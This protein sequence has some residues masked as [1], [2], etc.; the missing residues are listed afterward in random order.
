MLDHESQTANAWIENDMSRW[1]KRKAD[2]LRKQQTLVIRNCMG[3]ARRQS[4]NTIL[5]KNSETASIFCPFPRQ[6]NVVGVMGGLFGV[7][8]II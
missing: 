3:D 4:L 8:M 1:I 5:H 6:S 2:M 7:K